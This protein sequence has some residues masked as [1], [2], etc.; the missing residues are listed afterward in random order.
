MLI[1]IR[2]KYY[3]ANCIAQMHD[4]IKQLAISFA[5][6]WKDLREHLTML[7]KFMHFKIYSISAEILDYNSVTWKFIYGV[8]DLAFQWL[9]DLNHSKYTLAY[10]FRRSYLKKLALEISF[11]PWPKSSVNLVHV[12][13]C[14]LKIP[15][16]FFPFLLMFKM[17][18]KL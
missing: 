15:T 3:L 7:R 8:G 16:C 13:N 11:S 9:F 12:W 10:V 18:L 14:P 1:N 5:S 17:D 6:P 4:K 2:L